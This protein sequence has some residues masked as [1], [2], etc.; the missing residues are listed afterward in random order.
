MEA[1]AGPDSKS[2]RHQGGMGC[3]VS[4]PC[5]KSASTPKLLSAVI[6]TEGDG[7][8]AAVMST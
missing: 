7:G 3:L 1:T 4:G 2:G 5:W 8:A 6:H